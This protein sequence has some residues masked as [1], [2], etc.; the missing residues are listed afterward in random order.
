MRTPHNG[1]SPS[2]RS[3]A[4]LVSPAFLT[5]LRELDES[6]TASEADL[7]G[8][9][10]HEAIPGQPGAVAVLREWED[11]ERGDVPEGV[12]WHPETAR[13]LALALP[14]LGREALYHLAETE[15]A[16]GFALA[17]VYGEQGSQI[18]GWLRRYEPRTVE[19]L[20]LLEGLVR[21]PKAL[22]TLLQ[23]AGAGAIE[24]VGRILAAWL[25]A[26]GGQ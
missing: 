24:Q 13:L 10:K 14:L 2:T 4:N 1:T 7:S 16:E 6:L 3:T 19:A 25:E 21:S 23:A 9:W 8:P 15:S 18:A 17:A 11:L 20:H 22:A 5:L 26:G 12:L